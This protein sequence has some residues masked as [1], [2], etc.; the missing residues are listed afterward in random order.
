MALHHA[1]LSLDVP[2]FLGRYA[3]PWLNLFFLRR[4]NPVVG[5]LIG[6]FLVFQCVLRLAKLFRRL[7]VDRS[8]L[9][10]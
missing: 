2:G 6:T 10:S 8:N 7:L 4:I 1:S 9:P 3:G 5:Y